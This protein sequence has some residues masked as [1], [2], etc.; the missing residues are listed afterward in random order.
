LWGDS[1]DTIA[2]AYNLCKAYTTNGPYYA[3][4]R[5]TY[6]PTD[7]AYGTCGFVTQWNYGTF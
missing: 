3:N 1:T 6:A 4:M 5:Y 7:C 2:A